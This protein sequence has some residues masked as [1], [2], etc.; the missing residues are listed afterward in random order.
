MS[1][2]LEY[3]KQIDELT[4][5]A[6][7]AR[8]EE[9]GAAVVDIKAKIK[10]FGLT[11]EDLGLTEKPKRTR[12]PGAGRKGPKAAGARAEGS[13]RRGSRA[14]KPSPLKG[15][16]RKIKFKGPNGEPWTGVG[17]KPRWVMEAL[18]SGASL[19]QFAVSE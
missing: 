19:E 16:K 6:D 12:A 2:Y 9:R 7:A 5:K 11:A 8:K 14:G 18:A 1:N 10:A 3:L 17:R 13:G 15:V 4:K